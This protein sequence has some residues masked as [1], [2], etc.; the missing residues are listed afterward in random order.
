MNLFTYVPLVDA[1]VLENRTSFSRLKNTDASSMLCYY[2]VDF[3]FYI[4]V[5]NE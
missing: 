3:N 2:L 5:N 1:S 4:A